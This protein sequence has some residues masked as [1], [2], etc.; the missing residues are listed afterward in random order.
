MK[1]EDK[2][3]TAEELLKVA[4]LA[5]VLTSDKVAKHFMIT[6][7][8]FCRLKKSQPELAISYNKGANIRRQEGIKLP[9]KPVTP[10]LITITERTLNASWELQSNTNSLDNFQ[11]QF[12]ENKERELRKEFAELYFV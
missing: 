11:K 7:E 1:K 8:R 4:I 2:I 9:P 6:P 10:K 3:F 5:E 12:K